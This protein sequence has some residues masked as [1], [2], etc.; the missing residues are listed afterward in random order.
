M[1]LIGLQVKNWRWLVLGRGAL[2]FYYGSFAIFVTWWLSWTQSKY[3]GNWSPLL[4][5]WV[6]RWL[7]LMS[8]SLTCQ[9]SNVWLLL[10][11]EMMLGFGCGPKLQSTVWHLLS[12]MELSPFKC[13]RSGKIL[14]RLNL[15]CLHSVIFVW[16]EFPPPF[17]FFF[18]FNGFFSWCLW[19]TVST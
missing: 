1:P 2:F 4:P 18:F 17:F 7:T 13:D 3:S 11:F 8:A 6:S 14:V 12:S 5:E 10:L 9:T 19:R 16:I 15:A